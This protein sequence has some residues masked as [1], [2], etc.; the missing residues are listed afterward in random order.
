MDGAASWQ[1]GIAR[2]LFGTVMKLITRF[3]MKKGYFFREI[4]CPSREGLTWKR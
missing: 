1:E 2:R 3:Y 4:E